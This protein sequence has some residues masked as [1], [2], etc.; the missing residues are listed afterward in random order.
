MA[1]LLWHLKS[2]WQELLISSIWLPVVVTVAFTGNW[3]ATGV[4]LV[5]GA[6]SIGLICG[7][8]EWVGRRRQGPAR[9]GNADLPRKAIV[10]TVGRQSETILFSIRRQKPSFLGFL[11]TKDTVSVANDLLP[12]LD[13]IPEENVRIE[14]C[15]PSAIDDIRLKTGHILDWLLEAGKGLA[16]EYLVLD[17]TGGLTTMSLGAFTVAEERGIDSQYVRSDFDEFNRP[18]P[19][20]QR[21]VFISRHSAAPIPEQPR[22]QPSAA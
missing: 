22:T 18:K 17:P 9:G 19:G 14:T 5:L 6:V 15:E 21:L 12:Q 1:T 4:T 3:V 10:F 20:T 11:C 7:C 8:L 16:E 13:G 2:K